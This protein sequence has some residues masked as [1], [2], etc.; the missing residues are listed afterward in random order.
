MSTLKNLNI[1]NKIFSIQ[2]NK[3]IQYYFELIITDLGD[4]LDLQP[5]N[6]NV[7][8]RLLSEDIG[9]E[10]NVKILDLGVNRTYKNSSLIIEIYEKNEDFLPFIL[11]REAY[12]CFVPKEVKDNEMIKV[13]INQIIE[14]D[15][16]KAD[17]FRNWHTFIR[18][19]L[20]DRDFLIA[21]V[22]KLRK[23]F[24]IEASEEHETPVQFFFSEIHENALI[25]ENRNIANFYNELF[26][27]YTYKTS[28]SLYNE[29]IIKTLQKLLK[30][31]Y[32]NK[33]YVNL[34]DY[35]NLYK[36]LLE[37][38][39]IESNLSSLRFY[40]NLLWINNCTSIA[41]SYNIVYNAIGRSPLICE[42][43]FNPLLER[44]KV[45]RLFENFPF[46]SSPK[47]IENSFASKIT[48]VIN[49]PKVYLKD[50][51]K[52]LNKCKAHGYIID[53][54]VYF[55]KSVKNFLNLNYY[56]DISN[57][58]K[59]I[60]PSL[61]SYNKDY[62]CEHLINFPF[63]PPI[64]PLSLF[65]STILDRITYLS[66][67]GLT[68]DKR[69]ETLNAIKEDVE[70]EYRKQLTYITDFKES[71]KKLLN[72][73]QLKEEFITFLTQNQNQGFFFVHETLSLLI[74]NLTVIEK[75]SNKN[76][77]ISNAY[78]LTNFLQKNNVSN[79]LEENLLFQDITI[80]KIIFNDI[81][82][83]YFQ[84]IISLKKEIEKMQLFY[85][86][87][88]SCYNL[89]LFNINSI[90]SIIKNPDL[91][92]KIN[93]TKEERLK[94]AFKRAK[95][96]KITNQ[97]IEATITKFLANTP[98]I[99]VPMLLN[100]IITSQ[101][102]KYYP[103]TFL[104]DTPENHKK[105]EKFKSYF[106]RV[107]TS[108]LED[109]DTKDKLIQILPYSVNI[110]EKGKYISSLFQ[111][112]KEDLIAT[113]RNFWRGIVRKSQIRVKDFYDF[114][115][116]EFFY[117]KDFFEQFY[118]YSQKI[119]GKGNLGKYEKKR[120]SLRPN[121]FWSTDHRMENL[122]KN[123]RKRV[124]HQ[125]INFD[126][127]NINKLIEF[128]TE[129]EHLLLDHGEF[130][131]AKSSDFFNTY[132]KS[133]KFIPAFRKYGL[134]QYYIFFL[135]HDWN[136]ID[137]KLLF[138]NS[139]QSIKY[140]AQFEQNQP[141]FIKSLFP[142]RTP[143]KS[144]INWLAKS[145]KAVQECCFFFIKKFY[146]TTHFDHSISTAGWHYSSN[147]FK[148]HTQNVLFNPT[149]IPQI[150]N[151]REFNIDKYSNTAVFGPETPEFEMLTQIYNCRPLDIKSYLGTN[152][153]SIINRITSLLRKELIFPI[154]SFK[155]LGFQEKISLILPNVKTD[156]KD[157][158]VKLFSFFNRCRI[159]EI[160][161]DFYF[162]GFKEMKSFETGFL[163]EIWFPKCELDE[164]FDVFVYLFE[165]L[166]I[167]HYLILTDLVNGNTLIK[168]AFG[169]LKFLEKY[170]P[171]INL[172]W[173][174]KD[175]IW[176]N[177]K[178]FNEKFEPIY[179]DLFYGSKIDK[180][181]FSDRDYED[182]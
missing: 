23:F 5:I 137:L 126:S 26:E 33:K 111:T 108:E 170:N 41:P 163:I 29:D 68:F 128:R 114:E 65:E 24:K 56:S 83:K 141:V 109:S 81:L 116:K 138:I 36:K 140:P 124:S 75:I 60:N 177:H 30:L 73:A 101:F 6:K 107:L 155:N 112:F 53:K 122:I 13:Y 34:T 38:E 91:V 157:K 164:I 40:N 85:E 92:T 8:I 16:E 47:T 62:E 173:N 176:M 80:K 10:E 154:L 19:K 158:I 52:Y 1:L 160:E 113:R 125:K 104:K 169:N 172:K 90:T 143:N 48:M 88:N 59:I 134:A 171:L 39:K 22:D 64:Y 146:D 32:K 150:K 77:K 94:N 18:D 105:L 93:R 144:Y 167:N 152:K 106:P 153:Q 119:L 127:N 3:S 96:Y 37:E 17:G 14:N 181:K 27:K 49:L 78:K 87:I 139:F 162:H 84:S 15:L 12:Y 54:R 74:K 178:I 165:Y 98:P 69:V 35:Q 4:Y 179:P 58:S 9:V 63:N 7:E 180:T 182:Q 21:Q 55:F 51:K 121:L 117:T 130:I 145:K 103:E 66:V 175:K 46:V 28:K 149:Y 43:T 132:V 67:T 71:F 166:E 2:E 50:L 131:D 110:N 31:F 57:S 61:R 156:L 174:A 151:V 42:I 142:Y 115:N 118:I 102:A 129:L 95:S 44:N 97:K 20:V 100:T 79:V 86:V 89:K 135:P 147:H 45:K 11:L 70:N 120:K 161:G 133:I 123:E 76:P 159:Y 25:I 168:N 148:L 82:P 136:D 72:S 99:I